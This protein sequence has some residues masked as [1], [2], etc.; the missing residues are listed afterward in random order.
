MINYCHFNSIFIDDMNGHIGYGMVPSIDQG[1]KEGSKV[2]LL[3]GGKT[4]N[5]GTSLTASRLHRS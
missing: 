3:I 1:G 5:M 4:V 2:A